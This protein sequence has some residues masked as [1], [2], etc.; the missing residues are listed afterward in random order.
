MERALKTDYAGHE[1][2]Y[3]RLRVDGAAGW[4]K[5]A[6]EYAARKRLLREVVGEGHSP[7]AGRLLELGCGAG[8]LSLW[9][10]R[11]GY[12]VTGV[13]IAPTAVAWARERA[14]AEGV[15]ASF[16]EANVLQLDGLASKAFD[17]LLDGHCLHCIIGADRRRF[18]AEAMRLLKPGGFLLVDTM[19]GP[20][21]AGRLEGY[22]PVTKC[23]V[24]QGVASRY[25]GGPEEICGEAEAA[26]FRVLSSRITERTEVHGNMIVQAVK[27]G[28]ELE[29][30][31]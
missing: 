20:V 26:G 25:F 12:E 8:N 1:R 23:L 13:D 5:T 31:G 9:L 19:C 14:E 30:Q 2:V 3:R 4:D 15:A 27:P 28:E 10:V 22:D 7:R 6:A 17:F 24:R 16:L 21:D 29:S 11:Q 18:F